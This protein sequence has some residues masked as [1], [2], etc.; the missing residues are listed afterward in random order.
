MPTEL[1]THERGIVAAMLADPSIIDEIVVELDAD[2]FTSLDWRR[3]Y[4]AV[5][6]MHSGGK[7]LSDLNA[8]GAMIHAAGTAMDL[9]TNL[10]LRR[11]TNEGVPANRRWY[12]NEIRSAWKKRQ[13][14]AI[15]TSAQVKAGGQE[16][17]DQTIAW[18]EAQLDRL[19]IGGGAMESRR[20]ELVAD[21][22]LRELQESAVSRPGVLTG[23]YALDAVTG[24]VMPGELVIIAARPGCGKTSLAMQIAQHVAIRG[25]VLF[26]SLEMK[27]RELIRRSLSARS[28]VNSR[29]LRESKVTAADFDRLLAARHDLTGLMLEIAAPPRAT[30][31]QICGAAKY[32]KAVEGLRM[33]VVDYIG[34][35]Q[36]AQE[37]RRMERHLQVAQITAALKGLAKELDVP[38][39]ALAQLNRD[40]Q[41]REPTLANLRES[42]AIEQDADIVLLIHHPEEK[43]FDG[44][45]DLHVAKHR[46]GDT[47]IVALQWLPETTSF[48]DRP[49][50]GVP[51]TG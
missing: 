18:I 43:H 8:L 7:R 44:H 16:G 42:G 19:A 2:M 4:H 6:T 30:V 39:V 11:L 21:D 45:V 17:P 46:H 35:V 40:A 1:E 12:V 10:A 48:A 28:G 29:V 26:V 23:L 41:N 15:A 13:I 32:R 27:D 5:A 25:Q 31:Q 3:A 51:W 33:L 22:V 50:A 49:E 14:A 47:G 20:A 37:D 36:T 24:P 9:C 34:L 38:V